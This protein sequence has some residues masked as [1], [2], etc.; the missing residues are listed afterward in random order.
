MRGQIVPSSRWFGFGY[1]YSV[2]VAVAMVVAGWHLDAV[3]LRQLGVWLVAVLIG[4]VALGLLNT[5]VLARDLAR[6]SS[7]NAPTGRPQGES[8]GTYANSDSQEGGAVGT[9][10][11]GKLL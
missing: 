3:Q 7:E 6:A 8:L 11:Q 4:F 2:A 10:P 9:G 1:G 5:L